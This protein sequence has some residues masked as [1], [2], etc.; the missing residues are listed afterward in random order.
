M[1]KH[2]HWVNS[3]PKLRWVCICISSVRVSMGGTQM[4]KWCSEALSSHPAGWAWTHQ[5]QLHI[6]SLQR[7]GKA[8]AFDVDA[9]RHCSFRDLWKST[10]FYCTAV[11][12]IYFKKLMQLFWIHSACFAGHCSEGSGAV[13]FWCRL[14]GRSEV[15][16]NRRLFRLNDS[17]W[18]GEL[19]S[20]RSQFHV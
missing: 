17:S 9:K 14:G 16:A 2:P 13:C 8:R 11:T 15:A 7:R 20:S 10:Y 4:S 5:H 6:N 3:L 19:A 18:G 1:A 12:W